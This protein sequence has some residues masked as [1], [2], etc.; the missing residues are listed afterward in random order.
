MLHNVGIPQKRAQGS[1]NRERF[2]Q[3]KGGEVW[4][5]FSRRYFFRACVFQIEMARCRQV[6]KT[7]RRARD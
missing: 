5:G 3:T 4:R 2:F 7:R 6:G 1:H